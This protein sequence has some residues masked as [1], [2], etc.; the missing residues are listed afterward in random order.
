MKYL[1]TYE[2]V[3]DLMKP[4]SEED[5]RKVLDGLSPNKKIDNILQYKL[6]DKFTKDGLK[7][8]FDELSPDDKFDKVR[9]YN[10]SLKLYNEEEIRDI[11]D[12]ISNKYKLIIIIKKSYYS[13]YFEY[14]NNELL[15]MFLS[16]DFESKKEVIWDLITKYQF[17]I[18]WKNEVIRLFNFQNIK[19]Q[20]L[21]VIFKEKYLRMVD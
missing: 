8:M 6:Q 10:K 21:D 19:E 12:N 17:T 2:G 13:D 14:D 5:I 18:Q 3:R 4:K 7:K 15:D 11:L 20:E 9:M 16:L 1:K